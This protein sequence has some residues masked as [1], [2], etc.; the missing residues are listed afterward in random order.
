LASNG[1]RTRLFRAQGKTDRGG[2]SLEIA[3]RLGDVTGIT[4]ALG[5]LGLVAVLEGRYEDA[6]ELLGEDLQLCASRGDRS[7]GAEA[8]LGLAAA[9]AALGNH[10]LA[11]ELDVI[12]Q[13]VYDIDHSPFWDPGL[14]GRLREPLQEAWEQ[15][16]PSL[17]EALTAHR[18]RLTMDTAIAHLDRHA[19]PPQ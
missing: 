11:V 8:I 13:A 15:T 2:E 19:L 14:V 18:E 6:L 17:V 9:H 12:A 10:D 4:F 3:R 7:R 16:D 1:L 5:N